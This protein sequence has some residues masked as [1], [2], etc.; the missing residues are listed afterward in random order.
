MTPA[1]EQQPRRSTEH[2]VH[3]ESHWKENQSGRSNTECINAILQKLMEDP[4]ILCGSASQAWHFFEPDSNNQV[5]RKSFKEKVAALKVLTNEEILAL[6][7]YVDY[8]ASGQIDY[9]GWKAGLLLALASSKDLHNLPTEEEFNAWMFRIK[10]KLVAKG[11]TPKQA[12]D[13]VDL[14][15]DQRLTHEEFLHGMTKLEL[16]LS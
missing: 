12:F 4:K 6:C 10:A 9:D 15:K 7:D 11:L 5:D 8:A 1:G 16:G 14:N 3:K 13:V 2:F